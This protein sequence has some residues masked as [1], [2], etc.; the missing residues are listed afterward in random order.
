MLQTLQY[1][2]TENKVSKALFIVSKFE[3]KSK[4]QNEGKT[5]LEILKIF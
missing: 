3:A 1:C 5:I 2:K 4:E